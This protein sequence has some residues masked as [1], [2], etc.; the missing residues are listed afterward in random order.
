[1]LKCHV[2]L[3]AAQ[4]N[5]VSKIKPLGGIPRKVW[6][7]QTYQGSTLRL[8]DAVLVFG[9]PIVCDVIGLHIIKIP[10]KSRN[11]KL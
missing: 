7:T 3:P 1:M 6:G 8:C 9:W 10:T 5:N 2:S 11:H 4:Q